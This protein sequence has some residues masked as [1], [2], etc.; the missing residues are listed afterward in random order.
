M[1]YF[2][3]DLKQYEAVTSAIMKFSDGREA[4]EAINE[5]LSGEGSDEIKQ[6]I[7]SLLPQSGR[8]W[9][10]KKPAAISTDPFAKESGNLSVKVKTKAG[11]H[12][13]YFP[14]DG[15]DTAHHYGNKQFMFW[16]ASNKSEVIGNKIIEKLLKKM[17][18]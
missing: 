18:V 8:R 16:G 2:E 14:D 7:Q 9:K 12:Y 11:Y 6:S 4:E 15:A 5:Y 17:E 10:G 1:S 3:M 13:L